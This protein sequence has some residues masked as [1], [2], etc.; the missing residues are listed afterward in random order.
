MK[1]FASVLIAT[2]LLA[3]GQ[4]TSA[5]EGLFV[6]GSFTGFSMDSDRFLDGS[7]EAYIGGLSLGYRFFNDWALELNA[8]T[9]IAGHEMDVAQANF[10]YYFGEEKGQWRPYAV[11]GISYFDQ[12]DSL[13]DLRPDE[14]ETH[15]AQFGF[16]LAKMYSD[17]LELRGDVRIYHKVREGQDGTN[18]AAINFALNYYF[19]SRKQPEAEALPP[20]IPEPVR[21]LSEPAREPVKPV[22][23]V[24][25]SLN[26]EFEFDKA[27]VRAI[28]GDELET[29]ASAMQEHD[30]ILLVLEGHTDSR[31]SDAY[32]QDLSDRRAAAVKA[33]LVEDYGIPLGRISTVGYGE[34]R[35]I[36]S[37]DTD[38]GRARNRRVIGEMSY[39]EVL[40]D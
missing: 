11:A 19:E 15:Q 2:C 7:D 33:K 25:V 35:P 23:T 21:R 5:T 13:D 28:Y 31:G 36:A 22:E 14:E 37:N 30:D 16:G 39:T 26:V 1:Q 3:N 18:D 32:N 9:E 10:Y 12:E 29:I 27:V 8:G 20:R 6:G 24:T 4:A 17:H 34:S 38:E 40:A